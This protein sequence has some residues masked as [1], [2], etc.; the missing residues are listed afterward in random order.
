MMKSIETNELQ[1]LRGYFSF[2]Q[3]VEPDFLSRLISKYSEET[4]RLIRLMEN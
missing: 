4:I 1:Y 3:H 2:I